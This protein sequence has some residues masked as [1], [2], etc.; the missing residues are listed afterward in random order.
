MTSA[1]MLSDDTATGFL[2]DI[3]A[4]DRANVNDEVILLGE[5]ATNCITAD[6][7]AEIETIPTKYFLQDIEKGDKGI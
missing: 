7:I 3:T 6:E 5:S 4:D 1:V 2:V